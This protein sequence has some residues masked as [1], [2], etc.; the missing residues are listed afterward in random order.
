VELTVAQEPIDDRR[1]SVRLARAP[2]D[3]R[4]GEKAAGR[5]VVVAALALITSATV[6]EG[7][8]PASRPTLNVP[9]LAGP[10][11]IDGKLDDGVWL[12]AARIT[13]FTQMEPVDGAPATE[14]T[15]VWIAYDSR[16]LYLAFYA[17]YS[18]P[19]SIRANRSDRD[20][21]DR[22]D[23]ISVYLDTFLDQQ[24]A[25]MFAVNGQGVQADAMRNASLGGPNVGG[26][27][28]TSGSS[29]TGGG[30]GSS[31]GS[32]VRPIEEDPSWDALFD[33]RGGLVEDGWVAEMAIPF[34]SLRYP[35]V[36]DGQTHR[37]G[38]QVVRAIVSKDEQDV[39]S[40]VSRD[41]QG[42][43]TQMGTIG[44]LRDLSTTKNL[45]LQPE[46]TA[47]QFG[48]LDGRT[49]RYR[50]GAV[51]P[52]AGL[53]LKYGLTSN[54][55]LDVTYNPDFSQIE[56]DR[57]QIEVNQ[58]FPLFYE[59]KRPFFLEGKEIFDT[60]IPLLH[61]RTI[62]DPKFGGKLTGK[63][64]RTTF[65]ML[66]A[67]D[68]APGRVDDRAEPA[69][70]HSAHVAVGRL[71]YDLYR[72]SHIGA[73][74]TDRE[75]LDTSNRV[76]GVDGRFLLGA[77]HRLSFTVAAAQDERGS[78]ERQAGTAIDVNL[79]R[80]GRGL[81]YSISHVNY[82]PN[83]RSATGFI[84]RVDQQFTTVQGSYT[85]W[86]QNVIVSWGQF[87]IY[88]RN[89]NHAGQL[90]DE[91]LGTATFVQVVRNINASLQNWRT[92]ERFGGIA[93]LAYHHAVQGDLNFDRRFSTRFRWS[94]EDG[95]RYTETPFLG[96]STIGSAEFSFRPTSRF[97]TGLTA[98]LSRLVDPRDNAEVFDVRLYRTRTTYQF[99]PR[100]LVRNIL[101]Y[102]A[103]ENKFGVNLLL[104]YRINAGTVVFLGAD[105]RLQEGR[106]INSDFFDT[107]ALR[108]T[109][110]A[111]FFKLSYLFRQ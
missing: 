61:S 99:T 19:G 42:F 6:A 37:W 48:S 54:V 34:K 71:R 107:G 16:R 62:V 3:R 8:T 27:S 60:S 30:G 51:D 101:E 23:R 50:N 14:R 103:W 11:V 56:A 81:S 38:F 110:R 98:N 10:P 46:L 83:F 32:T 35:A 36:A 13:S 18:D 20:R 95:I 88:S 21:I 33:T 82:T 111:F 64:G 9:R 57:P 28:R 69:F 77:V 86:P 73:I 40:P 63:I 72:E 76:V 52:E 58:R 106:N 17:H 89:Y 66:V 15:E 25:F 5:L 80:L 93:F 2:K 45:E 109:S 108:R 12:E 90:D 26:R 75:F 79:T 100:L 4:R 29:S 85:F 87:G 22:D 31:T 97:E 47:V 104:T 92:I 74:V 84:R 43:L 49:G 44:G 68:E 55:V 91:M 78:G 53:N 59:E 102:D 7:Q 24:R 94:W 96:R 105:D 1:C 67:D 65:G 41:I 70:G 39:W